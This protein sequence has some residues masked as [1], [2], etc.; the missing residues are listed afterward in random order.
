MLR[1]RSNFKIFLRRPILHCYPPDI[2]SPCRLSVMTDKSATTTSVTFKGV[3][4]FLKTKDLAK[5][6]DF[7]VSSAWLRRG[8]KMACR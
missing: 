6:I 3:T 5:T 1:I 8:L 4:P 7:Y 2:G